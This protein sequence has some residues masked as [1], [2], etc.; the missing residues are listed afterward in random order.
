ML[1]FD[2]GRY[3]I[4]VGAA[5]VI[6]WW[7]GRDRFRHR[8]IRGSYA[9][10]SSMRRELA[11]SASTALIFSLVG[12]GLW[13]GTR[14]GIFRVAPGFGDRGW[15]YFLA[16]L[17]LLPIFHD[18]YFYWTH[19]AMHHRALFKVVHRVHHLSTNPSPCAAYA[20]APAEA[21]VQAAYVP[22]I[23]LVMPMSD[24][25]LF[26]F[27]LF[28]ICRNVM[29]HLGLE[30]FPQSFVRSRFLG[31]HTTTTHHAMHHHRFTGNYGL[32]FTFW[33][34]LMGTMHDRY[35]EEFD[36]ITSRSP[37][38]YETRQIKSAVQRQI[39]TDGDSDRGREDPND[40]AP[41]TRAL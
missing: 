35:E 18:A 27:L 23:A 34:R 21:L 11:Y 37:I 5:L 8:L 29:G 16:T 6:F 33:D 24:V 2:G 13:Y 22:L 31:V 40:C 15:A 30:L 28:M 14:A 7:W 1:A 4:V 39:N 25:A 20:F 9:M 10:A 3:A 12:V 41:A 36:R 17:V 26:L 38:P 19:R 32:Y